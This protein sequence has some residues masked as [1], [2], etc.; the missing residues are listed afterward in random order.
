MKNSQGA[1]Y[2][3]KQHKQEGS[4]V[5]TQYESVQLSVQYMVGADIHKVC[6][7]EWTKVQ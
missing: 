6:A 2:R 5:F 4:T 3:T 7:L 1:N